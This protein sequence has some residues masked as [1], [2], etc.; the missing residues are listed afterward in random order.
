[1]LITYYHCCSTIFDYPTP[2]GMY[3]SWQLLW[4]L[5]IK[6]LLGA[7]HFIFHVVFEAQFEGFVLAHVRQRIAL[8]TSS[9]C[10]KQEVVP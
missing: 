7:F 3:I 5:H 9:K 4:F 2:Q 6:F 10:L 8:A 1:M